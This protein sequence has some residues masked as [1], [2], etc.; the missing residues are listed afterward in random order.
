M[1]EIINSTKV[2][3]LS[4]LMLGCKSAIL[5]ESMD[6]NA[7]ASEAVLAPSYIAAGISSLPWGPGRSSSGA[8]GDYITI[9]LKDTFLITGVQTYVPIYSGQPMKQPGSFMLSYGYGNHSW[10]RYKGRSKEA[11]SLLY[12]FFTSLNNV[13]LVFRVILLKLCDAFS[14]W[15]VTSLSY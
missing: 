11:V 15:E 4:F 8:F 10:N 2:F 3:A 6:Y 1:V 14:F 5:K 9:S 7:T 12:H 13:L